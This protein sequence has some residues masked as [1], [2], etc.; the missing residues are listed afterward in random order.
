[1]NFA[2]ATS[3]HPSPTQAVGEVVGAIQEQIA[4][5]IDVCMLFATDAYGDSLWEI[6][7]TIDALL[8]PGV[9]IGCVAG[10]V[11]GKDQEIEFGPGIS[12]LAGQIG[13]I[14]AIEFSEDPYQGWV[15]PEI[16]WDSQKHSWIQ[17]L[18][19]SQASAMILLANRDTFPLEDFVAWSSSALPDLPII[20][21]VVPRLLNEGPTMFLGG[22]IRHHGAVGLILGSD[23]QFQTVLSHGCHPIGSPMAVTKCHDSIIYELA[24]RPALDQLKVLARDELTPEEVQMINDGALRI[25]RVLDEGAEFYGRSDFTILGV[26]GADP[27]RQA[28]AVTDFIEVGTTVQFHLA[29]GKKADEDL[30]ISLIGRKA[31]AGLIFSSTDRGSKMFT[32]PHHDANAL[33]RALGNVPIAGFFTESEIC[34]SVGQNFISTTSASILLLSEKINTSDKRSFKRRHKQR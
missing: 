4:G 13:A 5:N 23:V 28:I 22:H 20:G 30:D 10:A 24:G 29:D 32:K 1:M 17:A 33:D 25:G 3:Q 12:I 27:D 9:L 18:G 11:I 21:G 8:M 19:N 26:L 31:N 14:C 15:E 2:S 16:R 7:S 6:A 34:N